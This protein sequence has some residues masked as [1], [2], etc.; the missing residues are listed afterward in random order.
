MTRVVIYF[1]EKVDLREITNL[2][3]H[4]V[5]IFKIIFRLR[6]G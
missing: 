2:I 3:Q 5:V 6:K 1:A 4:F